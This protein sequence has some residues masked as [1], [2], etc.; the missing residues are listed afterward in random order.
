MV[1]R[2]EKFSF[3]ISEMS[4][5][6]H[7]IATDEMKKYGLKGPYVVYF[8]TLYRFPKGIT[9]AKLSELCS[10][11]KSDVSRAISILEKKRLIT[12]ENV[13]KNLYR[14]LIKLTEEGMELAEHINEKAKAAVEYS[15]QGISETHR[16]IFYDTLEIICK[17][18][19]ALS[20][21]GL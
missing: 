5:Y 11:D 4:H 7:K 17:N 14:A 19:Q 16:E 20:Q 1:D 21:K 3:A 8:T 6:W 2:F 12:K 13:N 15:S 18:L 10:R 9:A